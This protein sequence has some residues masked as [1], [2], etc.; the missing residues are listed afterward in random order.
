MRYESDRISAYP[1][2]SSSS[3][4][5]HLKVVER[6]PA[7]QEVT[8]S[9]NPRKLSESVLIQDPPPP[10]KSLRIVLL[11]LAATGVVTLILG[12]GAWAFKIGGA[13]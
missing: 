13:S 2:W 8:A 7:G 11:I 4:T 9:I 3:Q 10:P 6:F 1:K 5:P 12:V